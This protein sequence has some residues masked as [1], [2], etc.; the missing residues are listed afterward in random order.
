MPSWSA[1]CGSVQPVVRS[2]ALFPLCSRALYFASAPGSA[3]G[4]VSVRRRCTAASSNARNAGFANV[5]S[6]IISSRKSS[7]TVPRCAREAEAAVGHAGEYLGA[8]L[9]Q[10]FRYAMGVLS[11]SAV[12]GD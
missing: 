10:E 6:S 9:D 12:D 4:F 11:G 1:T 2:V 5:R 7:L 8:L 3:A